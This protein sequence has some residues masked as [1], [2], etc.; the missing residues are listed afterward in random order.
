MI[1]DE[2]KNVISSDGVIMSYQEWIDMVKS[3]MD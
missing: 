2:N 1:H 3:E